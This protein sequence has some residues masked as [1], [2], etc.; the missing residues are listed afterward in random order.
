MSLSVT[1]A[2]VA[3]LG[4]RLLRPADFG[5]LHY[6][7]FGMSPNIHEG[8]PRFGGG[9]M[10]LVPLGAEF[11]VEVRGIGLIDVASSDSAY[12]ST[13]AALE[14]HSALLFREQDVT[15]DIAG[16]RPPAYVNAPEH[17]TGSL[18]RLPRNG[19]LFRVQAVMIDRS[20]L[21]ATNAP[22]EAYGNVACYLRPCLPAAAAL[23]SLAAR[24]LAPLY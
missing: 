24:R 22:L 13:R 7:W 14:E 8:K 19:S 2:T 12:R 5:R 1:L 3:A 6:V 21:Q 23:I 10:E 17:P 16:N 18:K 4:H 9:V 20:S 15:D 11:G